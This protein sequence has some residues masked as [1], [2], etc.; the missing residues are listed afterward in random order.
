MKMAEPPSPYEHRSPAIADRALR[1]GSRSAPCGS[2]YRAALVYVCKQQHGQMPGAAR[3]RL[4][5]ELTPAG[6][7]VSGAVGRLHHHYIGRIKLDGLAA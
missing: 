5:V 2:G 3:N 4:R 1:I 6:G 7:I